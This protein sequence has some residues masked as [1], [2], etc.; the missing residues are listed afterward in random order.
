LDIAFHPDIVM[1]VGSCTLAVA[2][3][4]SLD[5]T[6]RQRNIRCKGGGIPSSPRTA[7]EPAGTNQF[8]CAH[9]AGYWRGSFQLSISIRQRGHAGWI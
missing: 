6:I 1:N 5:D 9:L 8:H 3:W 4:Q 7:V 2:R